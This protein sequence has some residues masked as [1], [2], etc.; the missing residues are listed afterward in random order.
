MKSTIKSVPVIALI[1]VSTATVGAQV[2]NLFVTSES[3]MACHNG[4]VTPAGEDVSIGVGWRGSMMANAARDPY[5]HAA[6]RREIS[7]TRPPRPPSKTSA[8]PATCRW[9]VS[10]PMPK[11]EQGEVFSHLPLSPATTSPWMDVSCSVCHQI[12]RREAR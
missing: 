10:R 9:R 8:Q 3:C 4:L 2:P 1:L 7:S 5:W 11:V 12:Q 6:V